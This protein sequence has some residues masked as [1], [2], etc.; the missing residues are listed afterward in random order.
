MLISEL[1]SLAQD[2]Y[3]AGLDI[4]VRAD[5]IA[6]QTVMSDIMRQWK[7]KYF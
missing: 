7:R 4:E 6:I 5:I 2:S 3:D 1:D